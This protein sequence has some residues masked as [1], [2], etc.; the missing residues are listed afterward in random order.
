MRSCR[1]HSTSVDKEGGHDPGLR[2]SADRSVRRS[3]R[4]RGN[5]GAR[6]GRRLS[7]STS[8][9][10][11]PGSARDAPSSAASRAIVSARCWRACS[12]AKASTIAF[13]SGPIGRPR[14]PIVATD[15]NGQPSY[16]FHGE[17]AAD[18]SLDPRPIC[19]PCCRRR[20]QALTFGSFT[21]VVEPVGS[22]FA[23][24]AERECG[25]RVIS[26]D[27]NLRPS[28]VGD[29]ARWAMAAE[30][31]YRTATIIKASDEDV[32]IAWGGRRVDC[33]SSR[34]LARAR[35]A[36]GGGD[37]G[38]EG[39][40]RLLRGGPCLDVRSFRRGARYGRRRR[41]VP[42]RPAGAACENRQADSRCDRRTR[43]AGDPR[44]ASATPSPP[45]PSPSRATVPTCRPRR[46][47]KR[48]SPRPTCPPR[49]PRSP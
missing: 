20:S 8:P 19:R 38:S 25:R 35:R 43:P 9:S 10:V 6:G 14:Y 32:R 44:P 12:L 39:R 27:P 13:S 45:R 47:S 22:A 29:M 2:R 26:V 15:D 34:L 40:Y 5:A 37:R 7:T 18:R 16:A 30:R 33:R 24:L 46:M 17:G 42:R 4:R 36:P 41:H 49:F 21:M 3:A 31:F 11:W 28:V 1:S 48:P 23:A